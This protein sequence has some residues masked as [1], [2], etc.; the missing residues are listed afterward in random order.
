VAAVVALH[1][2]AAAQERNS[3]AVAGSLELLS[4]ALAEG[5]VRRGGQDPPD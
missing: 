5:L 4:Q 3:L 1:A 2:A